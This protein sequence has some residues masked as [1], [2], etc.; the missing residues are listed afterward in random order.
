MHRFLKPLFAVLVTLGLAGC[1]GSYYNVPKERYV[2]KVRTLGV[3]PI[4][5]DPGSDIRQPQKDEVVA[6]IRELN[7]K[8]EQQL[9]AGL[10]ETGGY[11]MV[12]LLEG[13][14]DRQFENLY[15]RRELRDDAGVT[16]NKY[17]FKQQ[18]IRDLFSHANVDAVLVMVV[19]GI[20]RHDRVF[21]SNLLKYLDADYNSLILTAQIIDA[22]GTLLWEY[23]NFRQHSPA[24]PTFL[25]LQYPD[26]DEAAANLDEKVDIKFRT[27]A[28]LRRALEKDGKDYLFRATG[29][30]Q[31]YKTAFEDIVS[32]LRPEVR[33]FGKKEETKPS[34]QEQ[35]PAK[36]AEKQA[37]KPA[38]VK[39]AAEPKAAPAPPEPTAAEPAEKPLGNPEPIVET[40]VK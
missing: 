23:P 11:F 37:E 3:L 34:A 38:A 5:V 20:T 2:Q 31:I 6:L 35:Q 36:P 12:T 19:S 27:V 21:S 16:Y 14:A 1:A 30:S 25:P 10:R 18:E 40:P 22:D 32:L 26:F 8:N 33:I 17:F 15:F 9:V 39:P 28:G 7:R 13:D 29:T 24:L 4:F